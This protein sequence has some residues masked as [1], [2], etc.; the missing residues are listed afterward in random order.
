MWKSFESVQVLIIGDVMID[1]YLHGHVRRI[2][3]EAPVPVVELSETQD[4]LGGAGNVALNI[5]ALGATPYLCSVIGK[6]SE[7]NALLQ[8]MA[9][10]NLSTKGIIAAEHRKTT[11]K[12]RI[13]AGS[14]QMLRI[15]EET[16]SDL[17]EPEQLSL[18]TRIRAFLDTKKINV[19][20]F[21][22]YNKGVL[23][24]KLI[25]EV[26]KEALI[27]D[28]PTCV[29]PKHK[30][31]LEYKQCTLFKPNLKE[32]K[33]ALPLKIEPTLESLSDAADYLRSV[34]GNRYTMITLSEK[35]LF[36]HDG[37][38]GH[39]IPTRPRRI[40][41]VS[42]AGDTVIAMASVALATGVDLKTIAQWCNLA[43]GIVCE[44]PGVVPIDKLRLIEEWS[45][46][47]KHL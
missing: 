39:L 35:G 47:M 24:L 11:V 1:R 40:A 17:N 22:D 37:K 42:G 28:I 19:I 23:T 34:M 4:R 18:L 25:R 41:D 32:I 21:Q 43:G 31:F 27:R 3:P 38:Q 13:I 7:G 45:E 26:L 33:E 9:Q 14:Q 46:E 6:G 15:D 8:L 5:K 10:N 30:H 16:V 36:I 2:S 44:S 29:D 20:L 12:T